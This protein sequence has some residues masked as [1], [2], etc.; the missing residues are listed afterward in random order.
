[1]PWRMGVDGDGVSNCITEPRAKEWPRLTGKIQPAASGCGIV[2]KTIAPR[3]SADIDLHLIG[4]IPKPTD[5]VID[6]HANSIA[7]CER[8]NTATEER[9][10]YIDLIE[11]TDSDAN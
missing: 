8:V 2:R 5:A 7:D 1:M 4:G 10:V 9:A 6:R 3:T 11:V